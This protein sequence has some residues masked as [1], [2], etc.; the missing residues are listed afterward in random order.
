MNNNQNIPQQDNI[1]NN[2]KPNE[3]KANINNMEMDQFKKEFEKISL[4]NNFENFSNYN[5]VNKQQPNLNT[6]NK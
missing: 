1:N 3:V 5:F 4:K 6:D 2:F